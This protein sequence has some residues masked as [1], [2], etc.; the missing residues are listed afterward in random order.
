MALRTEYCTRDWVEKQARPVVVVVQPGLDEQPP[1]GS[2]RDADSYL[3]TGNSAGKE[4]RKQP[5]KEL[6]KRASKR[7]RE[8][9]VMV[10]RERRCPRHIWSV[11]GALEQ[12][13]SDGICNESNKRSASQRRIAASNGNISANCRSNR[14]GLNVR[15]EVI[16]RPA[17]SG[18]SANGLMW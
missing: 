15:G 14:H 13:Q 10:A 2:A 12:I 8:S 7:G 4:A 9:V 11:L 6:R 3:K 16:S 1:N 5:C 18:Q 17:L